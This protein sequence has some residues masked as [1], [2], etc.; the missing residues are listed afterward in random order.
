MRYIPLSEAKAHLSRIITESTEDHE[1][2]TITVNGRPAVVM[3]A[4]ADYDMLIDT[5][6]WLG[7]LG[8][9]QDAHEAR[10]PAAER[11][12]FTPAEVAAQYEAE[13][14]ASSVA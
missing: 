6:D 5:L 12:T 2:V 11:V 10:K 9:L 1:P 4:A 13:H 14:A 7:E 3:M 8:V